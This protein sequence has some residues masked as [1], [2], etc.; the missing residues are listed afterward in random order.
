MN[1]LVGIIVDSGHGGIDSGAV[2]NNLLEKDLTLQASK[3]M[4]KRLQELGI[5]SV[6]TRDDDTYLPK[7]DRIKKV[8]SLYNNS[9]N[10]ILVSNHINAGGERF[11]YH[12]II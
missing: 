7:A 3:Y 6:L 2:G 1:N 5:P 10:T 8:L 4:Y 12:Y 9:P 11:T